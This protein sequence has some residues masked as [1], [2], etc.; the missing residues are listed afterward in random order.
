MPFRVVTVWKEGRRPSIPALTAGGSPLQPT[1]VL[2][3]LC[4]NDCFGPGGGQR[5]TS[6]RLTTNPPQ[7]L[8]FIS[9]VADIQI[10]LQMCE[11]WK[12]AYELPSHRLEHLP[13][14]GWS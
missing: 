6:G 5:A 10:I 3:R 12:L 11:L 9:C 14:L 1:A 4:K 8:N 7:T 13:S 2:E